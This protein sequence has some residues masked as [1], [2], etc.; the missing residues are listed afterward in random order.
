M[1]VRPADQPLRPPTVVDEDLDEAD[2]LDGEADL[3]DDVDVEELAP[4]GP[5]APHFDGTQ[6]C[7]Q[8]DPEL[9][10]PEKGS[11]SAPAKKLCATCE[12]LAPCLEY[13]MTARIGGMPVQGV[14]GGTSARDR[15]ALRRELV[16][17]DVVDQ[18]LD[19]A[20]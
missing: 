10:F 9:F 6:L 13:G 12:F 7:A 17:V 2:L 4:T 15:A 1:C 11:P 20:S 3:L 5:L 19:V 16:P 18:R 14:W 8:V